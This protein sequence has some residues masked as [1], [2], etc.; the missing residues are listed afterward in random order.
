MVEHHCLVKKLIN[1][2]SGAGL[3]QKERIVEKILADSFI[4]CNAHLP[5]EDAACRLTHPSNAPATFSRKF[6]KNDE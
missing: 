3:S 1:E 4:T 5:F 6:E 2:V